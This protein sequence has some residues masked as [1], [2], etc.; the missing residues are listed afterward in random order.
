ACLVR[1]SFAKE[2]S[3]G[4]STSC[5]AADEP[6]REE[7]LMNGPPDEG[8]ALSGRDVAVPSETQ[9]I[10][11]ANVRY[12]RCCKA[13]SLIEKALLLIFPMRD[14]APDEPCPDA[15]IVR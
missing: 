9:S 8:H 6:A 7:P 4:E 15:F 1:L 5:F 11:T 14:L 2:T 3:A 13:P 10:R 12:V